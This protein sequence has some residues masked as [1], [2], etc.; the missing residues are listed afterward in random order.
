MLQYRK[1]MV[2]LSFARSGVN[3]LQNYVSQSTNT[4]FGRT[5]D[6]NTIIDEEV[7]GIIRNP[8]DS[9]TSALT[10][11]LELFDGNIDNYKN[12]SFLLGSIELYIQTIDWIKENAFCFVD[13]DI[14]V[15]DPK[16]TVAALA[17][18]IGLHFNDVEYNPQPLKDS[19]NDFFIV[20]S[21]NSKY[22]EQARAMVEAIDLSLAEKSYADALHKIKN[23]LV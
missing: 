4:F 7:I 17:D 5:H 11:S 10:M 15:S 8:K 12:N 1:D 19:E 21:K 9:L 23:G 2:Y 20:S 14:L 13:Y 3:F 16:T 22:Y 18:F 6:I